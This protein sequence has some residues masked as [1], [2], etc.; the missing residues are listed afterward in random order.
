M[1]Y[2]IVRPLRREWSR[3]TFSTSHLAPFTEQT[4]R[5]R[6]QQNNNHTDS[7]R[8]HVILNARMCK[9]FIVT[10]AARKAQSIEQHRI[11]NYKISEKVEG[12]RQLENAVWCTQCPFS[13]ILRYPG[14]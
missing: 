3:A 14:K 11:V 9:Q 10:A 7:S 6:P 2:C 13:G 5:S 4:A 1:P 12:G 8:N